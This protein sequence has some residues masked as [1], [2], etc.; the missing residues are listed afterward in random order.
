MSVVCSRSRRYAHQSPSRCRD[1]DHTARRAVLAGTE[2]MGISGLWELL[3]PVEER[4]DATT[5]AV[6][7]ISPH[8]RR[9]YR[10]GVDVSLWFRQCA[11]PYQ[12]G[13]HIQYGQNPE[14]RTLLY[15]LA[16]LF[17]K[18]IAAVFVADGP[19]RPDIK[20]DTEVCKKPH[21]LTKGMKDLVDAF[22]FEWIDA[23]AEAEAELAMM[24]QLGLIDAVLSDDGDTFMFGAEVVIRNACRKID[25]NDVSV[26]RMSA[27]QDHAKI[28][29]TRG[30]ILLLAVLAGGDYDKGL[31]NC[32]IRTAH[33]LAR[34]GLGDS[35]ITC[36]T[37]SADNTSLRTAL[38]DW[39]R[40]LK[41]CLRDDPSG[42]IG[43]RCRRL[44]ETL[45]HDFP[46]PDV[47]QA[48]VRPLTHPLDDVPLDDEFGRA[49][50]FDLARLRY[51][52]DRLFS[53]DSATLD[54]HFHNLVWPG[55]I[56]R[57]FAVQRLEVP[58]AE[59]QISL[60]DVG[61]LMKSAQQ[62]KQ[63][64]NT[65][66]YPECQVA[67]KSETLFRA[68]FDDRSYDGVK[69]K[70][71]NVSLWVPQVLLP[72]DFPSPPSSQQRARKRKNPKSSST[73]RAHPYKA[74]AS[75]SQGARVRA[76]LASSSSGQRATT[77]KTT[78]ST[79]SSMRVANTHISP[80]PSSSSAVARTRACPLTS[81]SAQRACPPSASTS[82]SHAPVPGSSLAPWVL[83]SSPSP[84]PSLPSPSSWR[85]WLLPD[86]PAD[87][88]TQAPTWQ[89]L[90]DPELASSSRLPLTPI[91]DAPRT[92]LDVDDRVLQL[93]SSDDIID[94]TLE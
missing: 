66:G 32:G 13:K 14:L 76:S 82:A 88:I 69:K 2:I 84:S 48:Y 72:T 36:V 16:N 51:L 83:D 68:T 7:S 81:S 75:S 5:L 33:G 3:S 56:L 10:I 52:C 11:A 78:T 55:A 15:K 40:R 46:D 23:P 49:M 57:I 70:I 39:R 91:H 6:E 74:S 17:A 21:P 1:R 42:Y 87:N 22:G 71:L 53:W 59:H 37:D 60:A 31:D 20:R 45:P 43:K 64:T 30:G 28:K 73:Q 4:R 94:L 50:H 44:A 9:L 38:S 93:S 35:L 27:I 92:R 62:K 54:T 86:E 12:Q 63:R 19:A 77:S 26:Y 89:A 80:A 85:S 65:G 79:S 24:N 41:E 34:Y 67:L 47:V 58:F 8:P 90:P 25:K 29:L 61:I 18:P